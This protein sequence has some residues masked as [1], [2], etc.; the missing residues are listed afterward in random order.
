MS[1]NRFKEL[2]EQIQ[3]IAQVPGRSKGD[4]PPATTD[5]AVPAP[6]QTPA[7]TG[8]VPTRHRPN[9]QQTGVGNTTF[10]NPDIR[11]MQLKLIQLATAVTSQLKLNDLAQAMQQPAQG[12]TPQANREA[13][14]AAGRASWGDF[15]TE[16]FARKSDIPGV[17]FD[18]SP[19]V[20]QMSKKNPSGLNRLSVVMDTMQRIGGPD[21]EIDP[22]GKWGP[23]TNAAL[24]N[25]YAF[26]FGMLN[27]AKA[28]NYTPKLY[29]VKDLAELKSGIPSEY[30]GI[31]LSDKIKN[32]PLITQHIQAI[33]NMFNEIKENILEVPKYQAFIEGTKE[34]ATFNKE[35]MKSKQPSQSVLNDQAFAS[36]QKTFAKG[37]PI[38]VKSD[39]NADFTANITINDL[40]SVDSVQKWINDNQLGNMYSIK[41]IVDSVRAAAKGIPIAQKPSAYQYENRKA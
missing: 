19:D 33:I 22:D 36:L 24:H 26:T 9:A 29:T 34:Y 30:N 12:Q 13:G 32:A 7:P 23:R 27:M 41:S 38:L 10:A 20:K 2:V 15:F 6:A 5:P 4:K 35:D 14:E 37:F 40:R 1:A 16:N 28:F 25:V 18:P 3:K 31:S 17:E 11:A 21:K 39:N 8:G